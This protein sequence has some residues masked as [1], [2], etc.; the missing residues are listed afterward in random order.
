MQHVSTTTISAFP[1]FHFEGDASQRRAFAR[2]KAEIRVECGIWVGAG[3]FEGVSVCRW[4]C[5]RKLY[6]FIH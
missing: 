6:N 2:V 3:E 1:H 5:M 4:A